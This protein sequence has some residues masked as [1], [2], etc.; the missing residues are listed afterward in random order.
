MYFC[1]KCNNK[2]EISNKIPNTQEINTVDEF[3]ELF[4]N[5]NNLDFNYKFK[6][7][8]T[9]LDKNKNFNKLDDKN[10]KKILDHFN[11]I[12]KISNV[13]F[14]CDKCNYNEPIQNGTI[15]LKSSYNKINNINLPKDENIILDHTLPRTKD[16]I[17]PNNC[18]SNSKKKS[19]RE[20]IFFRPDPKSYKLVY[21]CTSCSQKF[22][23]KN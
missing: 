23:P 12:N 22:S 14:V 1:P 21:I 9:E 16:F 3:L 2:L 5:V 20:A 6:F 4:N 15:L 8:L 7:K 18:I 11:K 10:K 13:F 17:C 19:L